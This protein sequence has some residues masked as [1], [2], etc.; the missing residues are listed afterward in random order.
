[1]SVQVVDAQCIFRMCSGSRLAALVK[2]CGSRIFFQLIIILDSLKSFDLF[3]CLF[4]QSFCNYFVKFWISRCKIRLPK[5]ESP[6]HMLHL[7]FFNT[8]LKNLLTEHARQQS[9]HYT[10]LCYRNYLEHIRGCSFL[11]REQRFT[12]PFCLRESL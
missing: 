9:K 12:T 2:P 10:L 11:K 4:F 6:L 1:M 8:F 7:R 5:I 3:Y